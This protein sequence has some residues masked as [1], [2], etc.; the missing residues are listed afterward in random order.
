MRKIFFLTVFCILSFMCKAQDVIYYDFDQSVLDSLKT[1][2]RFYEDLYH[3]DYKE[4]K[5]YAHIESFLNKYEIYLLEYSKGMP[6]G[7][8][9]VIQKSNR[10][11][12]ISDN[13]ILPILFSADIFSET[14]Q[15]D[16]IAE[17]PHAG[18]YVEVL[19][20]GGRQKVDK[21]RFLY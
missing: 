1:G 14:I 12:K 18:F 13:I 7:V 15:K 10:M 11:L 17:L 8:S 5:I 20:Q 3:K 6:S 21:T 9:E 4:L 16:K 2:I 19:L